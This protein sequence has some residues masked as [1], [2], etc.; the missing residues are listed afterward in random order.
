MSPFLNALR[1][2]YTVKVDWKGTKYLG[3]TILTDYQNCH[4]VLSMPGFINKV[5]AE[6]LVPRSQRDSDLLDLPP[7]KLPIRPNPESNS[8]HGPIRLPRTKV[9]A[10]SGY[11]NASLLCSHRGPLNPHGRP[12][13]RICSISTNVTRYGQNGESFAICL[14]PQKQC[15]SVPRFHNGIV[16]TI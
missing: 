12:R 16:T 3:M 4:V 13:I 1:A 5:V 6:I 8:G 7:L 11:R 15:H 10:A 9:R 14:Y 2:L